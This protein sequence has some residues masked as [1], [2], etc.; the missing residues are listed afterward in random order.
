VQEEW[1]YDKSSCTTNVDDIEGIVYGGI[2]SRFWLFRKHINSIDSI[3]E[4]QNLP[5]FAW[6][7]ITLILSHREVDLVIRN[8]AEMKIL[9]QFLIYRLKTLDGNKNS[10]V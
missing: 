8:E 7:C 9:L 2:S 3:Q 6:D 4:L 10:A 1:I 5:F